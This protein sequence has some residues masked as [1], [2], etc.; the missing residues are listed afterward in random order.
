MSTTRYPATLPPPSMPLTHQPDDVRLTSSLPGPT[1]ARPLSDDAGAAEQIQ[2]VYTHDELAT[3]LD[4]LQNDLIDGAAWFVADWPV[5]LGGSAVRRF[6]DAPSLPEPLPGIG[7]RVTAACE[8]RGRGVDPVA[9]TP[10]IPAFELASY[11]G[12]GGGPIWTDGNRTL[13]VNNGGAGAVGTASVHRPR[14]QGKYQ[15]EFRVVRLGNATNLGWMRL[16]ASPSSGVQASPNVDGPMFAVNV[17]NGQYSE[18]GNNLGF[19]PA[20]GAGLWR[21]VGDIDT[22][23]VWIA[24]D[25]SAWFGGGDPEAGTDPTL[26]TTLGR[27]DPGAPAVT[28]QDGFFVTPVTTYHG[29]TADLEAHVA[30]VKAFGDPDD[31]ANDA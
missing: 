20:T 28:L 31:T 18:T 29:A 7:W 26:T 27:L 21:F 17:G 23:D 12:V 22:G 4:W 30:G 5:P 11:L 9:L 6:V 24:K 25:G 13:E 2:F 1:Q 16:A 19:L 14:R 10:T 8:I 3:F 15:W